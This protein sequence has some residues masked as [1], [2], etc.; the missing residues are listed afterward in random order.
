MCVAGDWLI[1]CR[2]GVWEKRG[3]LRCLRAN[4]LSNAPTAK[5]QKEYDLQKRVNGVFIV[6][7][8]HRISDS[9]VRTGQ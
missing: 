1:V 5:V 2:S 6:R 7:D 3:R 9:K 8:L 4:H